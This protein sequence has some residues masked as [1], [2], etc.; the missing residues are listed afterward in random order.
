MIETTEQ[1]RADLMDEVLQDT[2]S[3]DL[4][5]ESAAK[6]MIREYVYRNYMLTRSD[7][8]E[9]EEVHEKMANTLADIS[10]ELLYYHIPALYMF[11]REF[12]MNFDEPLDNTD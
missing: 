7:E 4:N 6:E 11:C 3:F 5:D 1:Q 12:E 10:K 2:L 8:P 9:N